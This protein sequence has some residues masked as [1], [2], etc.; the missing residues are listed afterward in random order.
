MTVIT[1]SRQ[2]GSLGHE[3]G[4]LVANQLGYRVVWRDLIN[5]AAKR[6]GAP[7]IALAV[8]DELGLLGVTPTADERLKYVEAVTSVMRDF[9]E[10]GDVVIVGRGGQVALRDYPGVIHIRLIAAIDVRARRISVKDNISL[11]AAEA[12]INASDK[13]RADF[14]KNYYN[15]QLDDPELYH[16]ILNTGFISMESAADLI[17]HLVNNH[18]S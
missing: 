7:E 13:H 15:N 12:R 3:I 10:E 9:A 16:L 14:L 17:V 5:Q 18:R 2:M 11:Q 4:I 8:I 1:I 6:A